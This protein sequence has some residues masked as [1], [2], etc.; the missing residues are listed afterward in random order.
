MEKR[1]V[2]SAAAIMVRREGPVKH[3]RTNGHQRKKSGQAQ[4]ME[5]QP[6]PVSRLFAHARASSFSRAANNFCVNIL[7][8][9]FVRNVPT[10]GYATVERGGVKSVPPSF[11]FGSHS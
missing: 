4:S 9:L 2:A 11:E 1:R 5:I 7:S 6:E 10:A 8:L 3:S